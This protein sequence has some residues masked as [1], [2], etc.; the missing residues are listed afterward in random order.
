MK[1][2]LFIVYF[3]FQKMIMYKCLPDFLGVVAMADAHIEYGSAIETVVYSCGHKE[4]KRIIGNAEQ[5][6]D[7]LAFRKKGLCVDCYMKQLTLPPQ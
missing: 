2:L 7:K 5:R 6:K 3:F 1:R 4:R